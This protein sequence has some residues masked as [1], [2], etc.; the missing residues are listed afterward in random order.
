M[1]ENWAK[2]TTSYHKGYID[3]EQDFIVSIHKKRKSMDYSLGK[4]FKSDVEM[5]T[6]PI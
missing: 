3:T 4:A 5:I 1:Q 6:Q 2:H